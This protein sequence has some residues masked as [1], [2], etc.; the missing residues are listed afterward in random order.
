MYYE[1]LE[2]MYLSQ[3]MNQRLAVANTITECQVPLAARKFT[4]DRLT[5]CF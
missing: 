5:L 1:N 4:K 2:W 3:D